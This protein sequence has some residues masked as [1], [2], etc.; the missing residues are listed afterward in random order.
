GAIEVLRVR[1]EVKNLRRGVRPLRPCEEA[2][3]RSSLRVGF[4]AVRER[5]EI[6]RIEDVE[7]LQRV[8]RRLAEPVV[9]RA[10]SRASHLI[11]DAVEYAAPCFVL[12]EALI[13]KV[14]QET[15]ALGHAPADR[16]PDAGSWIGGR[17]V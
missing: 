5:K 13:Q 17:R 11:E 15:A 8:A 4:R 12:V 6:D 16:E 1:Q 7:E 10:A 3:G 14:P 9:E 2:V